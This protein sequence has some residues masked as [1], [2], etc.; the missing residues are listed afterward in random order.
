MINAIANAN[1]ISDKFSRN[2]K[3]LDLFVR[4]DGELKSH[5]PELHSNTAALVSNSKEMGIKDKDIVAAM[6]S[7]TF[8]NTFGDNI[9]VY[10]NALAQIL[11]FDARQ[12]AKTSQGH[13]AR[14]AESSNEY[15]TGFSR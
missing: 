3:F 11:D 7:A 4:Y 15:L 12:Q 10:A 5:N 8:G 2:P 1:G 9:L 13:V 14:L 6:L